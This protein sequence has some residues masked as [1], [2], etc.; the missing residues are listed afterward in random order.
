MANAFFSYFQRRSH[1]SA[2]SASAD[3]GRLGLFASPSDDVTSASGDK[4][5][6]FTST[7]NTHVH[8][9]AGE[10]ILDHIKVD[11]TALYVQTLHVISNSSDQIEQ[12][13]YREQ[14]RWFAVVLLSW[15]LLRVLQ[16]SY[17]SIWTSKILSSMKGAQGNIL[18]IQLPCTHSEMVTTGKSEI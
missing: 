11:L 16:Q 6:V 12:F 8:I 1:D 15:H 10:N 14:E 17:R 4:S 9:F 2:R 18:D 13:T 7:S 3:S 5:L